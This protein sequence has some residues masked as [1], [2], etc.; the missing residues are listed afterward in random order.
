MMPFIFVFINIFSLIKLFIAPSVF[1]FPQ[2]ICS[3]KQGRPSVLSA[4]YLIRTSI[5]RL[6]FMLCEG[7]HL[8]MD[9]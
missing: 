6:Y 2:T 1:W 3:A 5:C 4:E 9:T 7:F 8:E